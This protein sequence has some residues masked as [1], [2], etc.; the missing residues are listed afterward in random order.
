M[1]ISVLIRM[2]VAPW[3]AQAGL[4]QEEAE[5]CFR[6]PGSFAHTNDALAPRRGG[7]VLPQSRELRSCRYLF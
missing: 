1:Q 3:S 7:S 4:R 6:S 2:R 5:A